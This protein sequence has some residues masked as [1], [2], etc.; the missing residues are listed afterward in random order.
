[1][2]KIAVIPA[3]GA[4][5]LVLGCAATHEGVVGEPCLDQPPPATRPTDSRPPAVHPTDS[6]PPVRSR[7]NVASNLIFDRRPGRYTAED[8]TW[9]SD[10]PATESYFSPGQVVFFREHFHDVQGPGFNRF[11]Y[12]YRRFDT[13]RVGVAFK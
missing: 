13:H 6:P 1:M 5:V 11:D 2:W 3:M 12:T 4:M 7:L 9:R 10:W 8:F